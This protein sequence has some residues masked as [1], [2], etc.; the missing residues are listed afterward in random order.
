MASYLIT[1][2]SR[3][4][5]L[6]LTRLLA[7]SPSAGIIFATARR[8]SS[9]LQSIIDSSNGRV[10]YVF[11]DVTN[12]A[13]IASAVETITKKLNGKGLDVIINNA[14]VQILEIQG[15]TKM[16][17]LEE[18]LKVNVVAVHKVSSAFL[19]LLEKGT[20][21]KL[22]IIT[23]ELGSMGAKDYSAAAP[24]PSYKVSKAAV[25][26]IMVQYAMELKPKGYTV[27]GVSP[28][29]LKT[30][31]GGPGADLEPI[32]GAMQVLEILEKATPEDSGHFKQ[33]FVEGSEVYNGKDIPW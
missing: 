12:D 28:G 19:P 6:E 21:K 20:Q 5:G 3:G 2:C 9:A 14:G 18:T 23:S 26:M 15:A 16:H 17:S 7:K 8:E 24:F 13:S 29:W 27:F 1:G 25:N 33:I 30:D 22:V 4:L 11:L 31:L 10:H 32:V